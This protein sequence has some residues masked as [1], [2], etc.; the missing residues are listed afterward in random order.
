VGQRTTRMM[1][2][3]T[4]E[5][6]KGP[7]GMTY[8][9]DPPTFNLTFFL[10]LLAIVRVSTVCR[11]RLTTSHGNGGGKLSV[12]IC[13][14]LLWDIQGSYRSSSMVVTVHPVSVM[15]Q[16]G[17]PGVCVRRTVPRCVACVVAHVALVDVR[18]HVVVPVV[19]RYGTRVA[20][21]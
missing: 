20:A 8:A 19:Q 1:K 6:K 12:Q 10:L 18:I 3:Q 7:Y 5:R 13:C 16:L 4:H 14:T 17:N 9:C 2:G 11:L 15:V 21:M